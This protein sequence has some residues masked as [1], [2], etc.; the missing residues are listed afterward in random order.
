MCVALGN[1]T[2]AIWSMS[3]LTFDLGSYSKPQVWAWPPEPHN[4]SSVCLKEQLCLFYFSSRYF[5][6]PPRFF[7]WN[8]FHLLHI[9]YVLSRNHSKYFAKLSE[10]HIITLQFFNLKKTK[11]FCKSILTQIKWASLDIISNVLIKE[12]KALYWT[13]SAKRQVMSGKRY[14][15]ILYA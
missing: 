12:W 5:G 7:C 4:I 6:F 15:W 1:S 9:L 11:M 13:S 14:D 3:L 2:P 10:N 8:E